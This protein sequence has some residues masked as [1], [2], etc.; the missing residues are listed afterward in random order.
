MCLCFNCDNFSSQLL[1]F[2]PP[3]SVTFTA[4]DPCSLLASC[5]FSSVRQRVAQHRRSTSCRLLLYIRVPNFYHCFIFSVSPSNSIISIIFRAFQGLGGGGA[6]SLGTIIVIELFPLPQFPA[7]TARLSIAVSLGLLLGPVIG[8][9]ISA[10][11]TWRWIFIVK[12]VK[13]HNHT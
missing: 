11:T 12:Y 10:K 8:G 2:Y 5:Y 9:V 13:S 4:G 6:Y 3:N 7:A 1:L